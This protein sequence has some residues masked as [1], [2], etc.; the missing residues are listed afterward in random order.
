MEYNRETPLALFI[1]IPR[2]MF[3][4]NL[5]MLESLIDNK[6]ITLMVE[7]KKD[8]IED[9]IEK[10]ERII[11]KTKGNH[12]KYTFTHLDRQS[13]R[14]DIIGIYLTINQKFEEILGDEFDRFIK[15][16]KGIFAYNEFSSKVQAYLKLI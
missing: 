6:D 3:E 16:L 11:K 4:E 2:H 5:S 7:N 1:D 10:L 13:N 8:Y 15:Y 9:N 14:T 12:Y